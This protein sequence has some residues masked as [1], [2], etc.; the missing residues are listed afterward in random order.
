M[1]QR[2]RQI[3]QDVQLV[4][5]DLDADG[6]WVCLRAMNFAFKGVTPGPHAIT[7]QFRSVFGGSVFVHH[8]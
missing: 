8:R 1:I 4:E 2:V 6:D 5:Q 3:P 7:I